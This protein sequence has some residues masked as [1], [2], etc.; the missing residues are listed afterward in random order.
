MSF[1]SIRP[2]NYELL[3]LYSTSGYQWSSSYIYLQLVATYGEVIVYE[4]F[5]F[6]SML[7]ISEIAGFMYVLSYLLGLVFCIVYTYIYSLISDPQPQRWQ[8]KLIIAEW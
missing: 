4:V 7:G 1:V 2:T 6:L 5:G 3:A 8:Q